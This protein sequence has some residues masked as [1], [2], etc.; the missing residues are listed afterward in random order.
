MIERNIVLKVD[1]PKEVTVLADNGFLEIIIENL[2]GN[3]VKY[4]M[5]NDPVICG[6]NSALQTL[7]I[8]N[9]G[10][11]IP[12]EQLPYLF[13]RFYRTDDSR[14]SQVQGHG[15]GLSIAKNL[16]DLQQITI[17][18]TSEQGKGTTFTLDFSN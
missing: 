6:W 8:T 10:T 1:I 5:E 9:N 18:V 17:G 2:I 11:I 3:A 15:L 4:G 12:K 16:A 7:S 14:S 13:N